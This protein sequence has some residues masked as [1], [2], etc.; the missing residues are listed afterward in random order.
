MNAKVVIVNR[1][2]QKKIS[3][4]ISKRGKEEEGR[5]EGNINIRLFLVERSSS[6]LW[7][8]GEGDMTVLFST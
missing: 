8:K 6:L 5:R 4:A 1:G 7:G 3:S 2:W